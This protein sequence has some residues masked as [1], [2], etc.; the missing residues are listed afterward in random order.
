MRKPDFDPMIH[1]FVLAVALLAAACTKAVPEASNPSGEPA[2]PEAVE[3]PAVPAEPERT[4]VAFA[5]GF[6]IDAEAVKKRSL[7]V[8]FDGVSVYAAPERS[9]AFFEHEGPFGHF[10]PESPDSDWVR[11]A[12][13]GFGAFGWVNVRDFDDDDFYGDLESRA[14]SGNYFESLLPREY[15]LT[16]PGSPFRRHGPL[17]VADRGGREVR[18][19][20]HAGGLVGS[21]YYLLLDAPEDGLV[22]LLEQWWEGGFM[23]LFDLDREAEAARV[24]NEPVFN[25]ER[26]RFFAWGEVYGEALAFELFERV[27]G[28]F[29]R[30][31]TEPVSRYGE[32]GGRDLPTLSWDGNGRILA[33]FGEGLVLAL[34]A[35]NGWN[36]QSLILDVA[37]RR[38]APGDEP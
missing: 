7:Q 6:V 25:P 9:A 28:G 31:P 35:E 23:L 16:R 19:W 2:V 4:S 18:I 21:R 1:I 24:Y 17:L 36:L 5:D 10:F 20:N 33:D 30:V 14:K 26:S 3:A 15:A 22:L 12:E 37:D 29:E 34:S 27:P 13:P 8:A 11:F 32:A 38:N